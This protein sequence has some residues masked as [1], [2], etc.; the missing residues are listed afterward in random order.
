VGNDQYSVTS[1]EWR[2]DLTGFKNLSGL[3]VDGVRRGITAVFH[4]NSLWVDCC[5]TTTVVEYIP[6]L[7]DPVPAA[8]AAGSLRAPMPGSVLEVLVE[9]GQ[10]VSK[11][12]PLLKLEAM[13]M[14]HTIRTVAEGVVTAVYYAP[15]DTVAA[16]TELVR[17]E[18]A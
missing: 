12:Q 9:V 13:K 16:D 5:G 1:S 15:G 7:P 10:T 8:G 14:E 18:P 17:I 11:G 6:R 3:M 2:K 4:Q